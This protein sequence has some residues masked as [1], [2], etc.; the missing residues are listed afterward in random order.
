MQNLS[1]ISTLLLVFVGGGL[2]S[3]TRWS[4]SMFVRSLSLG[5]D[6]PLATLIA[7][8]LGCFLI[9]LSLAWAESSPYRLLIA[10]GFCGGFT[11]FSTLSLET[12][13]LLRHG[14]YGLL[15]LYLLL[16]VVLGIGC[17][18]LGLMCRSWIAK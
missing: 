16:S 17:V 13:E 9:G 7:N 5:G 6:F 18:A 10:V 3:V 14:A 1:S 4:L 2:G 15:V 11:T 8:L 12:W